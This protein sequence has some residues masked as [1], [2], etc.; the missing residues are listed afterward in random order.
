MTL[1]PTFQSRQIHVNSMLSKFNMKY[2]MNSIKWTP[3]VDLVHDVSVALGAPD[4]PFLWLSGE[5]NSFQM[6]EFKK[7]RVG[8][9][10]RKKASKW[11]ISKRERMSSLF[12]CVGY[13][14]RTHADYPFDSLSIS[15]QT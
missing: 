2:F 13:K 8:C 9:I 1:E 5:C 15:A 4:L 11:G 14:Y 6:L 3:T 7:R 10:G 12:I